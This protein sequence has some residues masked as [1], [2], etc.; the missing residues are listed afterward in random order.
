MRLSTTLNIFSLRSDGNAPARALEGIYACKE[1]GFDAVDVHFNEI[2]MT[3]THEE[4]DAFIEKA[5]EILRETGMPISQVHAR[6]G[7]VADYKDPQQL[8]DYYKHIIRTLELA[9]RLGAPWAVVHPLDFMTLCGTDE[10]EMFKRNVDFF[11]H[12]ISAVPCIGLAFEN[13]GRTYFCNAERLLKLRE[14]AGN[15]ERFGFCWDTGHGNLIEGLD[16][17]ENIMLLGKHLKCT[18]IQ[19]NRG[20]KDDHFMPYMG[21]IDWPKVVRA[22]KNSGYKGDFVYESAQPLKCLPED[23]VL[24]M[25][26]MKYTVK[27]GRYLLA[28]EG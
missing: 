3:L 5:K 11:N 27:L 6:F 21:I 23:N 12:A 24:R 10:E 15:H 20:E 14:A 13:T 1:A 4:Q 8:E 19:D 22:L 18:H 28:M 26:F 2:D 9:E 16:Q 7:H 25:E 17:A